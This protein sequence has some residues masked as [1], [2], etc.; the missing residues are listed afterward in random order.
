MIPSTNNESVNASYVPRPF[1]LLLTSLS[2]SACGL[3]MSRRNAYSFIIQLSRSELAPIPISLSTFV[4]FPQHATSNE[5][6]AVS[7]VWQKPGAGNAPISS[8]NASTHDPSVNQVRVHPSPRMTLYETNVVPGVATQV[9]D[10]VPLMV[11]TRLPPAQNELWNCMTLK[12]AKA[13]GSSAR[14]TAKNLIP[15]S[16]A[17][18]NG[19]LQNGRM[20]FTFVMWD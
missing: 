16:I 12:S 10:P 14:A 11:C 7:N 15:D 6:K 17:T 3:M 9:D 2:R 13:T 1:W 4:V 5:W 18:S 8:P 19:A 20:E